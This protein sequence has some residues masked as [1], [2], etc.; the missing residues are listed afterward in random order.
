MNKKKRERLEREVAAQEAKARS[1]SKRRRERIKVLWGFKVHDLKAET[2]YK[3]RLKEQKLKG[4][5]LTQLLRD[6][7]VAA[8]PVEEQ[9]EYV[10]NVFSIQVRKE[11]DADAFDAFSAVSRAEAPEPLATSEAAKTL[12][13][14]VGLQ[15]REIEYLRRFEQRVE[16]SRAHYPKELEDLIGKSTYAEAVAYIKTLPRG[17]DPKP[18][19]RYEIKR[20]RV[21]R[22]GLIEQEFGGPEKWDFL[23]G[24]VRP[25]IGNCLDDIFFGK[26]VHMWELQQL[27]GMYD[28]RF[29]RNLPSFRNGRERLYDW[30]AVEKIMHHLLAESRTA[31]KK[32]QRGKPLTRWLNDPD[33]RTRVLNGMRMRLHEISSQKRV[34]AAFLILIRHYLRDS[35]K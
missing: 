30:Q 12:V 33:V 7:A 16:T 4:H 19:E 13:E 24:G 28:K 17:P 6:C 18:K 8:A 20:R 5:R 2:P 21:P 9:S 11:E 1:E 34:K 35:A 32:R 3:R 26:G 10:E 29:P 14:L 31:S 22:V 23:R 27:F 25:Q 15:D